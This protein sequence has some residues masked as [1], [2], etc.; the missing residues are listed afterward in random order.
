MEGGHGGGRAQSGSNFNPSQISVF[1]LPLWFFMLSVSYLRSHCWIYDKRTDPIL[2]SKSFVI[3]VLRFHSFRADF[4]LCCEIDIWFHP[5][6]CG[7]PAVWATVLKRLFLLL[8]RGVCSP[9]E[10]QLTMNVR[11]WFLFLSWVPEDDGSR[12]GVRVRGGFEPRALTVLSTHGN[13][14]LYLW[15]CI[16]EPILCSLL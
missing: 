2:L 14:D 10:N 1:C 4:C 11:I 8:L 6:T 3:L 13:T 16:L 15:F 5:G 7:Y 9:A 12:G